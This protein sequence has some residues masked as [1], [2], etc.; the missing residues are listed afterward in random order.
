MT[1]HTVRA[2][3]LDLMYLSCISYSPRAVFISTEVSL[4]S[5]PTVAEFIR[6]TDDGVLRANWVTI[7]LE[8]K[9]KFAAKVGSRTDLSFEIRQSERCR[10]ATCVPA[11]LLQWLR[12]A[13][14]PVRT[15]AGLGLGRSGGNLLTAAL[16]FCDEVDVYGGGMYAHGAGSDTLYTHWYDSRFASSC[17]HPCLEVEASQ[18]AGLA[19]EALLRGQKVED[20]SRKAHFPSPFCTPNQICTALPPT[21]M[22]GKRR[23]SEAQTDFFFLAELRLYVLH[24][25]GHINWVWY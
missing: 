21:D 2:A 7:P 9:R 25:L 19:T 10:N 14:P 1:P 4:A 17:K 24:A 12:Y 5:P 6:C 15:K 3:E 13:Y 22:N 20:L 23:E 11:R 18:Q 8:A 16:A